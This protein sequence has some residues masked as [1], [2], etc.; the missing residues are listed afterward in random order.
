MEISR[1]AENE[2][3]E[4]ASERYHV[5]GAWVAIIFDPV[6]G[7][8]DYLNIA[9]WQHL[10]VIRFSVSAI[11]ALTLFAYKR[12]RF[13]SYWLV[14][15]PFMLISLQNA[16]T[17]ELIT[18]DD[19]TGH[20]LNYIALLIGAGMFILWRWV[21]SAFVIGVSIIATVFFIWLNPNFTLQE[22][23][24]HGGLLLLVV[25]IFM[26]VLIQTRYTLIMQTI[27][28]RLALEASN[29]ELE[30]KNK[31]ITDSIRYAQRIQDA[32]LPDLEE[33]RRFL[34][35]S[36]VLLKPQSMVSGDF[37]WF[38][39]EAPYT[40]IAAVDCTG[41]GVPGAFMSMKGDAILNQIVAV[42]K[43]R[44]PDQVLSRMHTAIQQGL[45][46]K[47]T[48]NRDGMDAAMCLINENEKTITF[49]G[50]K[51]PLVYVQNDELHR[52]KGSRSAIG[53]Y[54]QPELVNF[55]RT[56][57]SYAQNPISF[58]IFSDGFQDQFGG[59]A[60]SRKFGAKRFR[61]LLFDLHKKPMPEQE[62]RLDELFE[63]WR[64]AG[65]EK[66]IDDVLVIGVR[67]F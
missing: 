53:G 42:E 23:M 12:Y 17:F 39:H 40:L 26:I 18:L 47:A 64:T 46:Q 65:E 19:F 52:I 9:E 11:T 13:P 37:Y 67:L 60:E 45:K 54:R 44:Q 16:Y 56:T 28:A 33:I 24:I 62:A 61:Q 29:N 66:Q 5:I 38:W 48:K 43:I 36:F 50:A 63:E 55:E 21:F 25:A 49:A 41:H 6:F 31:H 8:T 14:F 10:L 58:Y 15:V 22:S 34:P 59:E 30:R 4:R 27:R 57:I 51:N 7:I 3:L 2:A 35:D 20:T 32:T 1:K